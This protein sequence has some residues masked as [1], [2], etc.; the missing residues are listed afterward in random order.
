MKIQDPF[1]H[2]S[3]PCKRCFA[4]LVERHGFSGPEEE[5]CGRERYIR[6]NKG[7]RFVSIAYEPYGNPV[8]E[9]FQPT[10][11]IKNRKFPKRPTKPLDMKTPKRGVDWNEELIEHY[12][13]FWAD[14]IENNDAEFIK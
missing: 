9:F 7:D 1:P 4:F 14:Q 13:A 11:E 5:Q 2:F 3:E 10:L 12:L 6:Y 8:I